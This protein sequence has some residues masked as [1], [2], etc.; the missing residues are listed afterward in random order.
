[1]AYDEFCPCNADYHECTD[2]QRKRAIAQN[3]F[4]RVLRSDITS[5]KTP[6]IVSN[7]EYSEQCAGEQWFTC[8]VFTME[9]KLIARRV[10]FAECDIVLAPMRRPESLEY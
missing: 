1:M 3:I 8:N 9:G 5:I 6:C 10:A 7:V 4:H 2:C